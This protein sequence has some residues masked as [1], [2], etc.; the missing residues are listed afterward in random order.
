MRVKP[1]QGAPC[2]G[3]GVNF[4][5][6]RHLDRPIGGRALITNAG[7]YRFRLILIPPTDRAAVRRLVISSGR[8]RTQPPALMYYGPACD[9]VARYLADVPERDWC[10]Y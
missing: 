9:L 2:T 4:E 6:T 8:A 10:F 1:P 3:A 7:P 5:T